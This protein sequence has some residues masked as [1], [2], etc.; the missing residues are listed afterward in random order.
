MPAE[1][2]GTQTIGNSLM[3]VAST[4]NGEMEQELSVDMGTR[5]CLLKLGKIK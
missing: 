3:T 2:V 4:G 1:E 5:E